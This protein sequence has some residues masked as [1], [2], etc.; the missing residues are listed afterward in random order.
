MRCGCD[1]CDKPS[2]E[3][4][5]EARIDEPT[6]VTYRHINYTS[7]LDKKQWDRIEQAIRNFNY[8]DKK[9]N[10]LYEKKKGVTYEIKP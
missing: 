8:L 5:L 10:E 2:Y 7:S 9:V 6:E 4:E 3:R 1:Y